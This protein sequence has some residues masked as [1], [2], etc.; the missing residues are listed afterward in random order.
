MYNI[1]GRNNVSPMFFVKKLKKNFK[2]VYLQ[3]MVKINHTEV[4]H[5]C[6]GL[7]VLGLHVLPNIRNIVENFFTKNIGGILPIFLPKTLCMSLAKVS[8]QKFESG[9]S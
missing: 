7:Y 1:L 5:R 2:Y 3:N 9:Y 8:Q 6:F 4:N